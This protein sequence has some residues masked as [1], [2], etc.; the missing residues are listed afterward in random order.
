MPT[1]KFCLLEGLHCQ[2]P[3]QPPARPHLRK[4]KMALGGSAPCVLGTLGSS[5]GPSSSSSP[6]C[7][8]SASSKMNMV[9]W[10]RRRVSCICLSNSSCTG[11][12]ELQTSKESSRLFLEPR[13]GGAP[14]AALHPQQLPN[15]SLRLGPHQAASQVTLSTCAQQVGTPGMKT[16]WEDLERSTSER[17]QAPA[18]RILQNLLSRTLEL[19]ATS[20]S[21][22]AEALGSR[23]QELEGAEA[24]SYTPLAFQKQRAHWHP[25]WATI[26]R[27]PACS[28]FVHRLYVACGIP[29]GAPPQVNPPPKV[30][31]VVLSWAQL[32]LR[33][34]SAGIHYL[35]MPAS[36]ASSSL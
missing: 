27:E 22:G 11:Q 26:S 25:D 24:A 30:S 8:F 36:L 35:S 3:L 15:P 5:C 9:W 16:C 23:P 4:R 18:R 12:G 17:E 33:G 28:I 29:W 14:K 13:C 32:L 34:S 7:S 21:S 1:S 20:P 10:Q 2:S 31:F 6:G 19:R